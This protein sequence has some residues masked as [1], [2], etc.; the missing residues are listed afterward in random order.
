MSHPHAEI[1]ATISAY[2]T[3][4]KQSRKNLGTQTKTFKKYN[5]E[6]KINK[7]PSLLKLYQKEI[8]ALTKRARYSEE[9]FNILSKEYVEKQDSKDDEQSSNKIS[10]EMTEQILA[11][12]KSKVTK[13]EITNKRLEQEVK[14]VECELMNLKNQDITIRELENKIEEL[15]SGADSSIQMQVITHK[16]KMEEIL[17]R[18][19]EHFQERVNEY[20]KKI[21]AA[22]DAVEKAREG[23]DA[24][25]TELF[26]LRSRV[27]EDQ[28]DSQNDINML[29]EDLQNANNRVQFLEHKIEQMTLKNTNNNNNNNNDDDGP[30]SSYEIRST[31][32]TKDAL[33]IQLR[34]QAELDSKDELIDRLNEKINGNKLNDV[35]AVFNK[36]VELKLAE[37]LKAVF[38]VLDEN[39]NDSVSMDELQKGLKKMKFDMN[40]VELKFLWDALNVDHTDSISYS[41]FERFC[42]SKSLSVNSNSSGYNKHTSNNYNDDIVN[43]LN[44]EILELK[45]ELNKRPSNELYAE[46]KSK[47]R[48]L[49]L[50][51]YNSIEEGNEDDMLAGNNEHRNN[52]KPISDLESI[53]V[54]KFH[55]MESK[56]TKYKNE[57]ADLNNKYK[58]EQNTLLKFKNDCE[59]KQK[60][61]DQLEEDLANRD[62]MTGTTPNGSFIDEC[63]FNNSRAKRSILQ[64]NSPSSASP[65]TTNTNSILQKIVDDAPA[66]P[67]ILQQHVTS[68]NQLSASMEDILRGQR[69]RYRKRVVELESRVSKSSQLLQSSRTSAEQLRADN[70]KLYEKIKYLQSYDRRKP[71]KEF[72]GR[73]PSKRSTLS[74]NKHVDLMESGS[75]SE[76]KKIYEQ[77]VNPFSQ[78]HKRE[79]KKR[80]ENLHSVDKI[81]LVGGRFFMK[82]RY[83]RAFLFF[84]F[85]FLHFILFMTMY[86]W[87]HA[88]HT[89]HIVRNVPHHNL[90]HSME[91]IVHK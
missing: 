18:E 84:Y 58:I 13:L 9:H 3:G 67:V 15:E 7:F 80:F 55:S 74:I 37:D 78:F 5:D 72:A 2:E 14:E 86:N 1:L 19:R 75:M 16:E 10:E 32:S 65:K 17:D 39:S 12:W 24:A 63:R 8:D 62:A 20:L 64:N 77:S 21:Q 23:Q 46:T 42:R 56:L 11:P 30:K 34:L 36:A 87:T 49:Q 25:Q 60:L 48:T 70:V 29:S 81:I 4:C 47:L 83:S 51:L 90:P 59:E 28:A 22:N 52:N 66:T 41:E 40:E 53:M 61:V 91:K 33:T 79:Q 69:D 82:N 73:A 27:D 71:S 54:K 88:H 76:Y 26:I 85:L 6:E 57:V 31:Y 35:A 89:F 44:I 45:N 38:S 43:K 68:N 50:I